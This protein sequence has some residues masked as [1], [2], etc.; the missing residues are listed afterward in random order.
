MATLPAAFRLL[1][2]PAV[3]ESFQARRPAES[4]GSRGPRPVGPCAGGAMM[5]APVI[6]LLL[7][8]TRAG[9]ES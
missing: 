5:K 9:G 6:G 8:V 1:S 7:L 4:L 3:K 2:P